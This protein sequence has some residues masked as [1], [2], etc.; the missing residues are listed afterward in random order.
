MKTS[1]LS[2]LRA[3]I[4]LSGLFLLPGCGGGDGL[5]Q[6]VIPSD[7]DPGAAQRPQVTL[8]ISN[9]TSDVGTVVITLL[10]EYAPKTVANFLQYVN[11]GFYNNTI[12][13]R[14]QAG[15]VMQ[16]G[17]YAAPLAADQT[18]VHKNTQ[19]KIELELKVSNVLATVAMARTN[20]LDSATSEFFI[21]LDDNSFLD[22]SAGGYAAFGYIKDFTTVNAM[23]QAPCQSSVVTGGTGTTAYGCLPV[24]NLVITSAVVTRP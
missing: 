14:H 6:L 1:I 17:G 18:P 24:P 23:V 9:G 20:E 8:T 22:T 10:P 4:V 7:N 12:F 15:F 11:T 21:N 2:A 13:H 3:G 5:Q 16:G 19:P